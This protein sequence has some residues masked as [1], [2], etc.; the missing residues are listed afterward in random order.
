M[1]SQA[2]RRVAETLGRYENQGDCVQVGELR[3]IFNGLADELDAEPPESVT[4]LGAFRRGVA[5]L[6]GEAVS[7]KAE[8]QPATPNVREKCEALA[9]F[10]ELIRDDEFISR[11]D[12]VA[13]RLATEARA[14]LAEP[15]AETPSVNAMLLNECVRLER[16][17]ACEVS[18][19][20]DR[21]DQK[22]VMLGAL[23]VVITIAK[24]QS[25]G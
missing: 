3:D 17:L 7:D 5:V 20:D 6:S 15:V 19:P 22:A 11:Y 10:A 18:D 14:A 4:A 8:T 12:H 1:N 13:A 9:T 25:H 21:N 24:G 2:I 23:R 16:W